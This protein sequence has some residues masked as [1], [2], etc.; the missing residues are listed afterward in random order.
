M[1]ERVNEV[2]VAASIKYLSA[3]DAEPSRSNQHE[4]GGLLKAGIGKYLGTPVNGKVTQLSAEMAYISD[5]RDVVLA[6]GKVSWYDS[7][8]KDE[9]RSPEWRLYYSSNE[10]TELIRESDLMLL[11][12]T[13]SNT[14]VMIFCPQGSQSEIHIRSIFGAIDELISDRM[15]AVDL[16]NVKIDMP[17]R[18]M[19]AKYGLNLDVGR[20]SD[21]QYLEIL[22]NKFGSSF[23]STKEF[24]K[25]ARSLFVNDFSAI[26]EPDFMLTSWME[27]EERIFRIFERHIVQ[28]KLDEGF[29]DVDEFIRVS[30]SI[31]NRRKSRVGHAFE[32]HISEVLNRNSVVYERGVVTE[33]KK[34]PDFLFPGKSSY[35]DP[36]YDSSDLYILGAKTTCKE[37]WR[38]VLSEAYR[39][40]I[41]HLITLEPSVSEPQTE[42]MKASRLQLVVPL[43]F[44]TGYSENQIDWILSFKEFISILPRK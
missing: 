21:E 28:K 24:S 38:Q 40:E 4:I 33:L 22:K 25:L 1:F 17:I 37:R 18:L 39:V 20:S 23:P 19:L 42:E 31:Q 32:N 6:E 11:A 3:V 2:F 43:P 12:L 14:V 8:F 29:L 35:D 9:K 10:V 41:K 7:R 44:Q 27:N 5:D 16:G 36:F 34:K 30:L 26:E 15:A 13:E